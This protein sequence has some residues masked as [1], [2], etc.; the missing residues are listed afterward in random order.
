MKKIVPILILA[1]IVVVVLIS[2]GGGERSYKERTQAFDDRAQKYTEVGFEFKKENR[3]EDAERA[4]LKAIEL[5]PMHEKQAYL[6]LAEVYRFGLKEKDSKTP[7]LLMKGLLQDAKDPIL[8]RA[9]A[10]Y[11][12]RV[13]N[14][15][16]ARYWYGRITEYYPNDIPAKQKLE[17]VGY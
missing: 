11:F 6:G 8:L 7:E 4:F 10:Q 16:Q 13:E 2:R 12:E 9:L 1:I 14:F 5:D 17:S 15:S 3:F